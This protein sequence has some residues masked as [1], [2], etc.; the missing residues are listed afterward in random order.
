MTV[1]PRIML[2]G[3]G[4]LIVAGASGA[5]HS[6]EWVAAGELP[7]SGLYFEQ[8]RVR[9]VLGEGEEW[10]G[11]ELSGS[12]N[13]GASFYQHEVADF[14]PPNPVLFTIPGFEDLEYTSFYTSPGEW[15]NT[16]YQ[17]GVVIVLNE[18]ATPQQIGATWCD[19]VT[20]Y[21]PGE[22]VIAQITLVYDEYWD[23]WDVEISVS[24]WVDPFASVS[25]TF[26]GQSGW[27][28]GWGGVC[29]DAIDFDRWEIGTSTPPTGGYA[30][31][32]IGPFIWWGVS[33]ANILGPAAG[34][35]AATL[36]GYAF[37]V[38]FAPTTHGVREATLSLEGWAVWDDGDPNGVWTWWEVQTVSLAGYGY[39]LG[40]LDEDADI[41]LADLATLLANYGGENM[42][43]ADG[44]LDQDA[45]VD[46]ED[47]AALLAVYG[48]E[49]PY[50]GYAV[51]PTI[52][53]R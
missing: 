7:N 5:F 26:R 6:V 33:E 4:L 2:I 44:D 28:V 36:D 39:C 43:Y 20:V 37:T 30:P 12:L 27:G 47:L 31:E 38:T 17:G 19:D 53:M 32:W 21:G 9:I 14:N 23:P 52:A 11:A 51:R 46:L 10:T 50:G 13:G 1:I 49:C 16:A 34:D 45:D 40:D 25:D 18:V 8:Y 41:D 48:T 35:F 42:S 22:F 15:P 3:T 24:S 29:P